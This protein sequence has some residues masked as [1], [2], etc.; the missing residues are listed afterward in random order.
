MSITLFANAPSPSVL[1]PL[2]DAPVFPDKTY[3][4]TYGDFLRK[5]EEVV[6]N[7]LIRQKPLHAREAPFESLYT[8]SEMLVNGLPRSPELL[9][10][11]MRPD[12]LD[13][14]FPCHLLNVAILSCKLGLD[15]KIEKPELV[16]LVVAALLHDIG[17]MLIDP[18]AFFHDRF[19]TQ[20]EKRILESHPLVASCFLENIK[21]EFPWLGKVVLEEHKRENDSGYPRGS[22]GEL[23]R[24]SRIIGMC[25]TY[26]ALTHTRHFR[27]AFHPA[28]SIKIILGEHGKS[29]QNGLVKTLI[30]SFSLYPVG[31]L[32]MLN[33]KK[34]VKVVSTVFGNPLKPNVREFDKESG[35]EDVIEL[36]KNHTIYIQGIVMD[37]KY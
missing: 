27:K 23:H 15:L 36:S 28:D 24:Y 8:L 6:L 17:M 35:A 34:I 21:D 14:F 2:Y 22:S 29:F 25:D 33:N 26:E 4:Q 1:E 9:V 31:S 32:V 3:S 5:I 20:K 30:D 10:E 18:A 7:T 11:A 16:N 12:Y 19:L 13:R 37:E